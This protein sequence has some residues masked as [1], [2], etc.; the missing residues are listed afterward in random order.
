MSLLKMLV[1]KTDYIQIL[2]HNFIE[3][4]YYVF[5][6]VFAGC[7]DL[8][9]N[10]VVLIFTSSSLWKNRQVVSTD[11]ARLIMYYYSVPR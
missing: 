6:V 5:F 3:H 2:I 8:D 9:G 7:R 4:V 10:A 1:S 11:L